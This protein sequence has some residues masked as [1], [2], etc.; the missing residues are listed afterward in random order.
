MLVSVW[1]Q[2]ALH[3]ILHRHQKSYL[4]RVK[5]DI[6][7][8]PEQNLFERDFLITIILILDELVERK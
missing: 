7:F 6:F 2:L 8:N 1:K 4:H 3:S 5:E